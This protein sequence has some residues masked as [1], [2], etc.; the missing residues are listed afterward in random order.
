[1]K[2]LRG[3]SKLLLSRLPARILGLLTLAVAYENKNRFSNRLYQLSQGIVAE[4]PFSGTR[5][6]PRTHGGASQELFGQLVGVYETPVMDVLTEKS[7]DT[8]V[9]IGS[10]SGY[11]LAG[12]LKSGF[13]KRA[14]GF[15]INPQSITEC[16]VRLGLNNVVAEVLGLA[17]EES[18]L[19]LVRDQNLNQPGT[20]VLCDIEGGEFS[21]FSDTLIHELS[22]VTVVIELHDTIGSET[23]KLVNNF[24]QSHRVEILKR[25]SWHC[26]TIASSSFSDL[27]DHQKMILLSEGREYNQEWLLARPKYL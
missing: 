4:G 7:W 10:E 13:A 1:M 22:A 6:L 3:A 26:E 11:Y 2:A 9:D 18:L 14:I 24:S 27:N 5:V 12:M 17:S 25:T 15:E 20:V 16:G 8:F 19:E 23:E 21:L